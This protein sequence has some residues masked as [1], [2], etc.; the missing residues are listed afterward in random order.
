MQETLFR[1]LSHARKEKEEKSDNP[2]FSK[3][4]DL[5]LVDG[6]TAHVNAA[7]QVADELGYGIKIAGMAKDDKHRTKSLVY[8]GREYDLRSNMTLLRFITE[9]QDE[10]HRVAV[11]YNRKLRTKRYTRSELDDI[12]GIGDARKKALIRHFKSVAAVKKADIHQLQEVEGIS[13]KIAVKIYNYFR[14]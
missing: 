12:E 2:K 13:E 1:R 3:M 9:I 10:T 4:P 7:R 5:I 8:E 14:D 11:E 6:G